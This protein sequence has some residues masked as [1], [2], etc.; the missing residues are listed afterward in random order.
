M[1]L[2]DTEKLIKRKYNRD[3]YS[4]HRERLLKKQ[5][6]YYQENREQRIIYQKKYND[7]LR[8]ISN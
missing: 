2:I 1:K 6:E 8:G 3:Y 7:E 5:N 4:R